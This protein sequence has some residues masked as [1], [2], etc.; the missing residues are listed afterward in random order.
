MNG[1]NRSTGQMLSGVD[2]LRQSIEDILT[3]PIGS[4][5]MGRDYGSRLYQLVDAPI[6]RALLVEIYS[7]TAEALLKWEPRFELTRVQVENITVGK[8][9]IGLEGVYIPDGKKL[10]MEGVLI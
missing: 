7:A 6:N 2:H 3:T 4:R 8:I 10:T 9:K 5:V 1:M